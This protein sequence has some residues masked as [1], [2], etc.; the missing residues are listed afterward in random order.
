MALAGSEAGRKESS[1]WVSAQR[2]PLQRDVKAQMS[3]C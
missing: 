2:V 3:L 1:E